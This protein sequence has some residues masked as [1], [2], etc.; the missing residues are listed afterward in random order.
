MEH[1]PIAVI[2]LSLAA[3]VGCAGQQAAPRTRALPNAFVLRVARVEVK[4]LRPDTGDRWDVADA[5]Y[6]DPGCDLLAF[7]GKMVS[8]VIGEG[9]RLLCGLAVRTPSLEKQPSNPDLQLRL[10]S[11]A[12]ATYESF[13]V[14]D[15]LSFNFNYE[16]LVPSAAIPTEGILVEVLDADAGQDPEAIASFRLTGDQLDEIVHSPRGLRDLASGAATRFE[17]AAAVYAPTK[18]VRTQ[19]EAQSPPT[20]ARARPLYAGELVSL[21]SK[22]KYTVGTLYSTAIGPEGYPGG[23]LRGYNFDLEPF[24]SAPHACG[25][26]LVGSHGRVDGA[27]IGAGSRFVV[28]TAGPLR[29]GVNDNDPGNNRGWVAFEGE[30]RLPTSAEWNAALAEAP[31]P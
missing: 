17:V 10:S 11:A 12:G 22:G 31:A 14:P 7:G 26:A 21:H 15:A 16:F 28:T 29:V 24:K 19:L 25:V 1:R 2:A 23:Q 13:V 18:I 27:V 9:V 5:P 4:A 8:S 20:A 30:T 3:W 6:P